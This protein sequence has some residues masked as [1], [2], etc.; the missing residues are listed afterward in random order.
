MLG[1]IGTATSRMLFAADVD[2]LLPEG[3]GTT[4]AGQPELF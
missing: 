1:E 4:L 3:V 2:H